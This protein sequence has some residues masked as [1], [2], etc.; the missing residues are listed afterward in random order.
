MRCLKQSKEFK[1]YDPKIRF[2]KDL[3]RSTLKM[4]KNTSYNWRAFGF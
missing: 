1:I 4:I 2:G 3:L